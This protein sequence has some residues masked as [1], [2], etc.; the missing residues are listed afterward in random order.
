MR[1]FPEIHWAEGMFLRPQHLQMFA[2]QVA[3]RIAAAGQQVQPY[4]WGVSAID[5]A[6]DQLDN[7]VF[8]AR[9]LAA[10]LKDGTRLQLPTNLRAEPRS[11]KEQLNRSDGRLPVYLGVPR[12]VDGEANTRSRQEDVESPQ[13]QDLRYLVEALE[14]A[15]ENRGGEPRDI[16]IRKLNGRFFF[17]DED[18]EGYE[19]LPIALI[20][21][22]GH[23][24]ATPVLDDEFVPPV[25]DVAAWRTLAELGDKVLNKVEARYRVLRAGI[26]E[27]R[28]VLDTE[29][30]GGWQ[31]VFKLQIVGSF[32]HV[33]RQLVAVPGTHPFQLYLEL[34]R[35][36]GELSIFEKGGAEVLQLPP[37]DHDRLGPC[38]RELAFAV[39]RLLDQILTGGFIKVPFRPEGDLLIAR[40]QQEYLEAI[41][42]IYLCIESNLDANEIE[43]RIVTS[44]IAAS[45]DLA[46]LGLSR[47]RGLE[48][49]LQKESPRGLPADRNLHY[50]SIAQEND[51]WRGV[52]RRQEAAISNADPLLRFSIY[53][54][55][56]DRAAAGGRGGYSPK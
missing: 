43:Q 51:Y 24:K 42:E 10:V 33:L 48:I 5:V 34:A 49:E 15:D 28:M 56:K 6:E 18:R 8:E 27:R 32:L 55:L 4:F 50:Y 13:S 22:A 23:G 38:F 36:A 17:G 3:S 52:V 44:K 16:E 39:H 11:F 21:R 7:F 14:V 47:L 12:L 46:M 25:T 2:Q 54:V 29:R 19:W 26:D 53:I 9:R 30:R 35:L 20:R 41:E 31:L 1:F 45:A 37:Y 40:L